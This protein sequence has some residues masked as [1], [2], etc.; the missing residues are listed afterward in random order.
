MKLNGTHK[1]KANSSRVFNAILDPSVLQQCIPGCESVE[2]LDASRLQVN[3]TTSLPGLKGPYGVVVN[4]LQRQDPNLIV[5]G[6]K[7]QGR[8]GSVDATANI[9]IADEADGA[10]V[11][12]DASADL[13]GPIAIANNPV[14]KGVVNSTLNS[15]FQNLDKVLA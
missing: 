1:F 3:V 7:R 4:L 5:L 14:G 11:T 9:S 13:S 8:G 10:L 2:V 6:V 12:Y 15:V